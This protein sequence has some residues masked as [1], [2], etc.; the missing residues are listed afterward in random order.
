MFFFNAITIASISHI[1]CTF[2]ENIMT[3]YT[4]ILLAR[5]EQDKIENIAFTNGTFSV[6]PSIYA[7][8]LP[9]GAK[10]ALDR[11]LATAIGVFINSDDSMQLLQMQKFLKGEADSPVY[12][13]LNQNE[14]IENV[15]KVLEDALPGVKVYIALAEGFT[16]YS[17]YLELNFSGIDFTLTKFGYGGEDQPDIV[18]SE[19]ATL[20]TFSHPLPNGAP[21]ASSITMT[22]TDGSE[23]QV[24]DLREEIDPSTDLPYLI[25]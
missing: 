22:G 25:V 7:K 11:T 3:V 8:T 17:E 6:D 21:F 20:G 23:I 2:K 4:Q 13:G 10:H 1:L 15:R 18:G 16:P 24:V 14:R 9:A 19:F 5:L 12:D